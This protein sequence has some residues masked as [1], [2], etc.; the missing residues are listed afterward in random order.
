[1][2]FLWERPGRVTVLGLASLNSS[3][4]CWGIRTVPSCLVPRIDSGKET[5]RV[6]CEK[7]IKEVVGGV[8]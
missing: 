5:I 4:R 8:E 7:L 3:S 1:M 2:G 6:V